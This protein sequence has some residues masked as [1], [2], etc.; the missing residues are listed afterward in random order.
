MKHKI[1][2]TDEKELQKLLSEKREA[3]RG[4]KFSVAGG[5][6]KDVK[7]AHNLKKEIARILTKLNEA[8]AK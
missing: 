3:L 2:T 1:T 4:F 6:T 5:K 8:K 7:I